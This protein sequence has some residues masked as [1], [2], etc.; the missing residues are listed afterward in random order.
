[1][2]LDPA[3]GEVV[4]NLDDER[5]VVEM[6]RFGLGEPGVKGAVVESVFQT[7]RDI[8]PQT[9]R[10]QLLRR[11]HPSN[12]SFAR[13]PEA[14]T[15]ATPATL[16]NASGWGKLRAWKWLLC[17]DFGPFHT[18][19]TA[20]ER[21]PYASRHAA[22]GLWIFFLRKVTARE[23]ERAP[24]YSL[25]G[26][27]RRPLLA[28]FWMKRTYQPNVR[29]RKRRHGF[30]ARMATRAGRTILKRRRAKGRKRLSA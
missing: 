19:S 21:A 30:R 1:M 5:L 9:V 17:R 12:R 10:A 4:G 3:A 24:L 16:L 22:S 14:A 7:R 23:P 27:S 18:L 29:R 8:G 15:I 20:V 13:L 11:L 28:N 26:R 25:A 2:A 6:L